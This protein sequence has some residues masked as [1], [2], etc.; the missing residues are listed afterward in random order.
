VTVYICCGISP[1]VD[2]FRQDH[3]QHMMKPHELRA[4]PAEPSRNV[5]MDL[6]TGLL[7]EHRNELDGRVAG[8]KSHFLMDDL[9]PF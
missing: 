2:D 3:V 4:I 7:K 9:Q 6:N 5:L 1:T 8:C